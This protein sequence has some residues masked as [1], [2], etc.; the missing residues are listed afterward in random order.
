MTDYLSNFVM[1]SRSWN[2]RKD[3]EVENYPDP[4]R[5]AKKEL[6]QATTGPDHVYL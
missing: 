3:D 5:P 1:P 2:T 4:E 6:F